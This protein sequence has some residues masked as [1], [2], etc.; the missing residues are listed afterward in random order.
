[1]STYGIRFIIGR[2]AFLALARDFCLS[3]SER[4]VTPERIGLYPGAQ[5]AVN[6]QPPLRVSWNESIAA[7]L[8]VTEGAAD[9]FRLGM[10]HVLLSLCLTAAAVS[11]PTALD[12]T[13]ALSP[14][15]DDAM[16]TWTACS[17]S[18][19]CTQSTEIVA[20]QSERDE[21]HS[22]VVDMPQVISLAY[23][24]P[25]TWGSLPTSVRQYEQ[26][27]ATP[28]LQLAPYEQPPATP[29]LQLAMNPEIEGSN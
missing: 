6:W 25:E 5:R 10:K 3:R 23:A 29:M 15:G 20:L 7:T 27:P 4:S 13:R 28:M 18:R 2:P 22:V 26:P 19:P 14:E 21:V 17:S 9:R 12:L 24:S 1:M 8:F 11:A 16:S